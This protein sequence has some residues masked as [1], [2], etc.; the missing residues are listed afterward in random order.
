M[1]FELVVMMVVMVGGDASCDCV[2]VMFVM[3]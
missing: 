2:D 3:A 1:E